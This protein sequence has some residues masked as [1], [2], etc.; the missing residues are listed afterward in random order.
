VHGKRLDDA[1]FPAVLTALSQTTAEASVEG[2]LEQRETIK[3]VVDGVDAYAKVVERHDD[4]RVTLAFTDVS[5][6][7]KTWLTS[8]LERSSS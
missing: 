4:Y 3:L 8:Q 6:G 1:A 2:T 7:L 5:P